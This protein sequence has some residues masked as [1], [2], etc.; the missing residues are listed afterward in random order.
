MGGSDGADE[1]SDDTFNEIRENLQASEDFSD[2]D[3]LEP[4]E[5]DETTE[6]EA[7]SGFSFE[8]ED[9]SA[10]APKKKSPAANGGLPN[11]L[12]DEYNKDYWKCITVG[13]SDNF[14]KMTDITQGAIYTVP[15]S[16]I[17]KALRYL[18]LPSV[19]ASLRLCS[20]TCRCKREPKCYLRGQTTLS[21]LTHRHSYFQQ[22]NEADATKYLADLVRPSNAHVGTTGGN[23]RTRFKWVLDGREVCD[24]FFRTV[25]GV[26]KDKMKGVRRLLGG[27]GSIPA[28][29]LRPER[30]RVKFAWCL[31]FWNE[32]FKN[33]QRPNANT[34]LFPV[35]TSYPCIYEDFFTPW[36]K[37]TLSIEL[38]DMPCLGWL[39]MARHDPRFSDVKSR[40]KHHHCRCQECANLQAKRL[41]TFNN[42]CDK[43]AFQLE[44]QDH[45]NEKRWWREY[46][47]ALILS[48]KHDP[49]AL[50]VYWFDDTEKM[51][52]PKFTKRPMKNLP[53]ARFNLVPFLIADLG[54][55]KDYY[56]YMS[57]GRFR[58]GAN[59]LC[60]TLLSTFRATKNG[61]DDSRFARKLALIADNYSE[62][63]N[64]TLLAFASQLVMLRWYDEIIFTYGPTGH[65]HNG[66][67]Q[68]HQ[69]HNE[70]LGN[71]TSATFVHFIARYPQAWRQEHT[72]PTPCVLD[73]Q[74]DWDAYFKPFIH[75]IAGHTNTA[76]DPVGIRGFRIARGGGG[77]VSVQWK[78]RRRAGSGGELMVKSTRKD[79]WC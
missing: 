13:K 59:R 67:D 55:Q 38:D 28:P 3:D 77:V 61:S 19:A 21:I 44:W 26:S 24:D 73:V 57:G 1:E 34:R 35:N 60:T 11:Y 27:E 68:Q 78:T 22:L 6:E 63:K 52:F 58:K 9:G 15:I 54:R 50:N 74:Y 25:F 20:G 62:N 39:M 16:R 8:E 53:V 69:I 18:H 31:S 43:E 10:G 14:V 64:N 76:G 48:A 33:C 12:Q 56:I 71:F 17:N 30:P 46:E 5:D 4:M 75:P 49:R 2:D 47:Q 72:R 36:F 29:R 40:P 45:Q 66:G 37:H 42:Q 79:L 23:A 51:G 70:V 65:T 32:F 7:W 41:L